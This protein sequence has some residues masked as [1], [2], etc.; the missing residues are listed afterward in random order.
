MRSEKGKAGRAGVVRTS[1]AGRQAGGR[2]SSLRQ[3]E[4]CEN[5]EG[6]RAR[7]QETTQSSGLGLSLPPPLVPPSPLS[8]P[9]HTPTSAKAVSVCHFFSPR[10]AVLNRLPN[11]AASWVLEQLPKQTHRVPGLE[12][13]AGAPESNFCLVQR[14]TEAWRGQGNTQ[15]LPG[16]EPGSS[17]LTL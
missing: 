2:L 14:G 17:V 4:V 5:V 1:V 15:G 8:P 7:Q 10:W 12:G 11:L 6:F 16:A 3:S 9:P 13:P